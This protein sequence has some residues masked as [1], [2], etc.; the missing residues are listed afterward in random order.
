MSGYKIDKPGKVIVFLEKSPNH[1]F[2]TTLESIKLFNENNS[3]DPFT[4]FSDLG[5]N[6]YLSCIPKAKPE[7]SQ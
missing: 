7:N 1:T 6:I 3:T 2:F 5:G 4:G